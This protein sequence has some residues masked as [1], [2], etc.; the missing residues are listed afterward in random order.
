MPV[1]EV[2]LSFRN[3]EM[4]PAYADIVLDD[5]ISIRDL[6][7][8]HSPRGYSV[9]MPSKTVRGGRRVDI[10]HPIT[11]EARRA[12]EEAVMAEYRKVTGEGK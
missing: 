5:S 11:P 9:S 10:V 8:I 7:I 6:R 3:H 4:V 2:K 12:I 1:T